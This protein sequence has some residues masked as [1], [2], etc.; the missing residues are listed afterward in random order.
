MQLLETKESWLESELFTDNVLSDDCISKYFN[1]TSYNNDF[2]GEDED[3]GK[4]IATYKLASFNTQED[5]FEFLKKDLSVEIYY[6]DDCDSYLIN[7]CDLNLFETGQTI[8]EALTL[9]EES[10]K[11]VFKRYA[12]LEPNELT[13]DAKKLLAKFNSY[14]SNEL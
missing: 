11:R 10:C 1:S 14:F 6:L 8:P 3:L 13:L 4:F 5:G 2:L 12:S 7:S 9:F